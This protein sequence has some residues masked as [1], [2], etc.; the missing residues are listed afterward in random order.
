MMPETCVPCSETLGSKAQVVGTGRVVPGE[1]A[2]DDH[3]A[4]RE[5]PLPA[6]EA[7]GGAQAVG[8]EERGAR[9]DAVVDHSDLDAR[10]RGRAVGAPERDG[11]DERGHGVRQR[12][13]DRDRVD[14]GD[15]RHPLDAREIARAGTLHGE[16]I[17]HDAVAALDRDAGHLRAQARREARPAPGASCAR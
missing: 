8:R 9:V 16:R 1:A 11:A 4:A 6:R 7:R 13:I 10:A 17:E 15:A 5:A 2:R 3:P 14:V 12:V